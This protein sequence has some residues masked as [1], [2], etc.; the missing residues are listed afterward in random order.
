MAKKVKAEVFVPEVVADGVTTAEKINPM[1]ES[2][3]FVVN[4]APGNWIK[5]SAAEAHK[6]E[7]Q[8]LLKGYDPINGEVL[9]KEKK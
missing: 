5:A 9:L 8:G 2:I 7:E 3:A 4:R 1:D 6:Y